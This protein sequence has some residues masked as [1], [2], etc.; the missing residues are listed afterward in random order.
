M[1]YITGLPYNEERLQGGETIP[2]LL[3]NFHDTIKS[4]DKTNISLHGYKYKS[5]P[6]SSIWP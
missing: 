2:L 1:D 6:T 5:F 4:A 3:D